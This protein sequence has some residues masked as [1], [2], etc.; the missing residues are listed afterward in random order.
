MAFTTIVSDFLSLVDSMGCYREST[1]LARL[2]GRTQRE[3]DPG[4][5][6]LLSPWL[7]AHRGRLVSQGGFNALS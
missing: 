3:R 1:V 2:E 4:G 7:S 6:L 5:V